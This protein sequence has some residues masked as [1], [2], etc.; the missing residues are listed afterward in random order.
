MAIV[1]PLVL[2]GGRIQQLQSGDNL[3][4]GADRLQRTF[5]PATAI[6]TAMYVDGASTVDKARA[7]VVGT[8][9]VLGLAAEA[10]GAGADGG[11]I[12]NGQM[13]ATT[14]EWDLVT[15]QT[16]GLTTNSL[17]FLSSAA[18]GLLVIEPSVPS[19]SGEFI[20]R[21]G[22][23]LSPTEMEVRIMPEVKL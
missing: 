14:G 4:T 5:T 13:A 15:G 16:G 9:D 17:Y 7:N 23:A 20:K 3:D 1:K 19:G 10:V 8:V 11:V 6:C 18:I 12:T 21:I 22:L 2:N